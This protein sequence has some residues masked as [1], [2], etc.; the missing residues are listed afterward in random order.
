ME[1]RENL[2]LGTINPACIV[3][4]IAC[5]SHNRPSLRSSQDLNFNLLG[6]HNARTGD[7]FHDPL[8]HGNFRKGRHT[9]RTTD[10]SFNVTYVF[11]KVSLF[12]SGNT[13]AYDNFE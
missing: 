8:V 6:I 2:D 10:T 5:A 11:Y 13:Y 7:V 4:C 12:S 1:R 9:Q 3:Y